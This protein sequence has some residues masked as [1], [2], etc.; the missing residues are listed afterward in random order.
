MKAPQVM[1]DP[2]KDPYAY[3]VQ[4]FNQDDY[5]QQ[6]Q[7]FV[8]GSPIN[9]R[10]IL[11]IGGDRYAYRGDD[12]RVSVMSTTDMALQQTAKEH[13]T[14]IGALLASGG[15]VFGPDREISVGG[16]VFKERS[17]YNAIEGKQL[18]PESVPVKSGGA[19]LAGVEN[20]IRNLATAY[21]L[22][23]MK[24]KTEGARNYQAIR[25]KL[26][27]GMS[28]EWVA[29]NILKP[30]YPGYNFAFVDPGSFS[31]WP[32]WGGYS[33]GEAE[34]M[35]YWRGEALGIPTSDGKQMSYYYDH[36]GSKV[37]D[38][39]GRMI[40]GSLLEFAAKI[41][42]MTM[43]EL[44]GVAKGGTKEGSLVAGGE[45]GTLKAQAQAIKAAPPKENLTVGE[46]GALILKHQ[47]DPEEATRLMNEVRIA[48][49]GD[50]TLDWGAFKAV[51]VGLQWTDAQLWK[52]YKG[53][54]NALNFVGNVVL[55]IPIPGTTKE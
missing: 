11:G 5:F 43:E 41:G 24:G 20:E 17:V 15:K 55:D 34:V 47:Y 6:R 28:Y 2:E 12:E 48:G 31:S 30:A 8:T 40:S 42:S 45:K 18:A 52:L 46:L 14:T 33:H 1:A 39:Q 44:K 36:Q 7:N 37:F 53:T 27:A 19:P 13:G 25:A 3:G 22:Q 29:K 51:L 35:T 50:K 26:D 16:Y 9:K 54:W 23:D 32:I 49:P 21:A 4:L 10:K 38:S